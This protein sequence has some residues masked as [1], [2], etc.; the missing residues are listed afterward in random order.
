MFNLFRQVF[1][2]SF[3]FSYKHSRFCT[4]FNQKHYSIGLQNTTEKQNFNYTYMKQIKTK[5]LI[6]RLTEKQLQTINVIAE[7]HGQTKS[8]F[9]R[10]HFINL[11]NTYNEKTDN[12]I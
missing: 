2:M 3:F 7:K 4:N 10:T 8:E 6:V 11:L 9:T 5:L 12:K 1:F